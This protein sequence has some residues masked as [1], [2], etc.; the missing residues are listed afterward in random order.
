MDDKATAWF[1][2]FTGQNLSCFTST[3][4]LAKLNRT[5]NTHSLYVML[6]PYWWILPYYYISYAETFYFNARKNTQYSN[7]RDPTFV[8]KQSRAMFMNS[9]LVHW[10]CRMRTPHVRTPT[11]F[12]C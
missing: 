2:Y 7:E 9:A 3:R 11:A 5:E 10:V 12:Q 4:E 8:T 1:E 6:L